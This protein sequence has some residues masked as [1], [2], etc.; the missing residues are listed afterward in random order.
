MAGVPN[1]GS[2]PLA[3][4]ADDDEEIL[5]MVTRYLAARLSFL[6]GRL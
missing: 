3:I 6:G 2:A 4:V 1:E 5:A